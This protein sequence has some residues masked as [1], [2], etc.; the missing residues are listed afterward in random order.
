[1]AGSGSSLFGPSSQYIKTNSG[2]FIATEGSNIRERLMLSDLRIPY[3]QI[4]KSR[5]ILKKGANN[6][7]LN[8]LGLGDNVTFLTIKAVYD[9]KS[10]IE[11][12]NYIVYNYYDYPVKNF[13][14]AQLLV[15]TGNS[16]NRVTQLYLSNPNIN[17]PVYLDIMVAVID[18]N[19]SFFNDDVNQNSTSFT[20]LEYTDIKSFVV[21][22]S[23]AI[24]DKNTPSRALIYLGLPYINSITLNGTF[25]IIDDESYGTI[26]LNFLTEYDAN[27]ANSLI[28]Y[29]LE[30]PNVDI[31]TITPSYDIL[32]PIIYFNSTAGLTGSYIVNYTGATSGV[33]YNTLS[34]GL[35]YSTSLLLSSG[36]GSVI[37]KDKL[38]SLLIDYIEDSRDGLMEMMDSEMIISSTSSVVENI[39]IVGTY[40][41]TFN[42]EDIANNNLNNI[43][44]NLIVN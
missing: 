10:V 1:M 12:D 43:N 41:L 13:T 16:T 2:D 25:L 42:F 4:L 36:T 34:D 20:G 29:V 18:D 33:P 30:N 11:T 21:G 24:Y 23:I 44:I 31:S 14:F 22:E 17:Y 38:R 32:P 35:T 40:S 3:K 37:Y 5:V 19:Y 39:N 7:L 28:N 9:A 15:L 8:H 6:H 27:Q 26:F